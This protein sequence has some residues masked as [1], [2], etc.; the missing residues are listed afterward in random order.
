[1]EYELR[2]IHDSRK[3]FYGKA[4][5]REENGKI[6]LRSY[7]TD[8]AY[9]K[10]GRAVVRGMYSNTTLRHIKEFLIQHG[11]EADSWKQIEKDYPEPENTEEGQEGEGSGQESALGG[12]LKAVSMVCALGSIMCKDQKE[13]NN[14]DK[15]MIGTVQGISF[16]DDWDSLS[17]EEKARRLEGAKKQIA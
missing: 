12:Q 15:R 17:E 5:V 10:E 7:N 9:I 6:I 16:P 8:V 13:K 4:N 11:F 1:M 3:S 2:A 14:W